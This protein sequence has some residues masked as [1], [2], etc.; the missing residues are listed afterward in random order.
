MRYR[1]YLLEPGT[2]P[3][4]TASLAPGLSAELW[5][6]RLL[7][8]VPPGV[9]G[10]AFKVWWIFHQLHLFSNRDY[11]LFV[12]RDGTRVV[13]RSGVY[14]GYL[15]FPFM[16]ARDLQIGDTWT[17][18]EYRGRGLA[19]YAAAEIVMRLA[20]EERRFWYLVESG[21]ASS[22]RVIERVGFRCQGEGQR[23]PRWGIEALGAYHL[24]HSQAA[25]NRQEHTF[26]NSGD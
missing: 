5:R 15:R 22:I 21:N 26:P 2:A 17:D 9:A 6:P 14:P 4:R 8:P 18:P 16:S 12:I 1:F 11:S 7:E 13:H 24:Q 19:Q 23:S 20:T 3:H 25:Q 10:R